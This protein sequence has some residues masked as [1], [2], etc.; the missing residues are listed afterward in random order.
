MGE[1]PSGGGT[2]PRPP[3]VR[4]AGCPCSRTPPLLARALGA[5]ARRR[6]ALASRPRPDRESGHPAAGDK[7]PGQV[8]VGSRDRAPRHRPDRRARIDQLLFQRQCLH[9]R[10]P[11]DG[12]QHSRRRDR[13]DRPAHFHQAAT[14]YPAPS[15][16]S[17]WAARRRLHLLQQALGQQHPGLRALVH[18]PRHRSDAQ[19]RRP[20]AP[21]ERGHRHSNSDETL[22]AGTFIE[23]DATGPGVYGGG[24]RPAGKRGIGAHQPGRAGE[25]ESDDG[26]AVGRAAA[27]DDVHCRPGHG[28]D[29]RRHAA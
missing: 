10:R 12:L 11:R 16:R 2:N 1:R 25:Q 3:R 15:S 24:S 5:R 22:G 20:P 18:K 9:A 29:E 4:L 17:S 13:G 8:V 23:G 7:E 27:H 26:R 6:L 19:D 14:S 21:G 28:A